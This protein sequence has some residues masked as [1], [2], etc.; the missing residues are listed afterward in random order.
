MWHYSSNDKLCK[1]IKLLYVRQPRGH[2]FRGALIQ[3]EP[4]IINRE[5]REQESYLKEFLSLSSPL[6]RD[7]I[8]KYSV[9]LR[10]ILRIKSKK[11]TQYSDCL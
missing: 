8:V 11:M 5:F 10:V 7:I 3:G 9:C 2:K 1:V 4:I 6:L